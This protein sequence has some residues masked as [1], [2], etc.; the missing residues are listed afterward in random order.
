MFV[1]SMGQYSDPSIQQRGCYMGSPRLQLRPGKELTQDKWPNTGHGH[2]QDLQS[3]SKCFVAKSLGYKD[4]FI[5]DA[6]L[7]SFSLLS[8]KGSQTIQDNTE[9]NKH[10]FACPTQRSG[11]SGPYIEKRVSSREYAYFM[12]S[13]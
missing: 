7:K 8:G 3:F 4:A 10:E 11:V 6:P 5:R 12:P 1:L 13:W 2:W 9:Q